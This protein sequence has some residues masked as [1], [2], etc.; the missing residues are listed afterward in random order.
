MRAESA[1]LH[2]ELDKTT[3]TIAK[4]TRTIAKNTRTIAEKTKVIIAI[5]AR[6][7]DLADEADRRKSKMKSLKQQLA[8]HENANSPSGNDPQ[9]YEEEKMPQRDPGAC[10]EAGG[11][12]GED[13]KDTGGQPA[14]DK[15]KAGGQPGMSV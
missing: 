12:K 1:I 7:Q 10:E 15:R 14:E 2:H 9:G 5:E 3:K 11:R 8:A 13:D 6:V 4:N